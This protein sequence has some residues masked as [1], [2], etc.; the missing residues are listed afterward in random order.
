MIKS[1]QGTCYVP[2]TV[3]YVVEG[4]AVR[5]SDESPVVC[6]LHD[7]FSVSQKI[8]SWTRIFHSLLCM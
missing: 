6:L 8:S 2:G 7:G 3:F 1:L 4:R 5:K